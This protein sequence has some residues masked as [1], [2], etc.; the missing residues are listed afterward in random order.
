MKLKKQATRDIYLAFLIISI[1]LESLRKT[2]LRKRAIGDLYLA[3]SIIFI[4]LAF[5][6]FGFQM[7]GAVFLIIGVLIGIFGM[8]IKKIMIE[9]ENQKTPNKVKTL[10]I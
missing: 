8:K 5:L 2:H 3:S 10:K 7:N 1:Y 4:Y 6:Y 9:R